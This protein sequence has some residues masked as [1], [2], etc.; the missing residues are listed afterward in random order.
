MRRWSLLARVS[1]GAAA[2]VALS[3]ASAQQYQPPRASGYADVAKLPDWSGVWATD[4][5]NL[6]GNRAVEPKLTPKAKEQL[7]AF[8]E[9]ERVEGVSQEAQVHCMPSGMPGIMRQPYPIEI[10][11]SPGRVTIFAETYSQA[12]RIYTDGSPLPEDPDL[13][14]N[15][16]SVGRWEGDTLYVDTVGF[17]PQTNII[18]GIPHRGD[19]RIREKIW[20]DSP[21]KLLIE[22][23]ITNPEIFAEPYVSVQGYRLEKDWKIREYTCAENNRL[24]SGEGGANVDLGF[25]VLDDDPFAPE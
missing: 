11:F 15:G 1:V 21:G 9:K 5:S 22:T 20:M 10:L 7:D 16:S 17:S 12:R 13:L 18:A 23:T 3:G 6:F 25:D 19:T 8:R 24:I 2:F 4:W 14:F